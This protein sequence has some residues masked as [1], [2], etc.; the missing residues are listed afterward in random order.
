MNSIHSKCN[1]KEGWTITWHQTC[2]EYD[3][4]TCFACKDPVIR[5]E[6]FILKTP[7]D[8]QFCFHKSCFYLPGDIDH[9]LH[10]HPLTVHRSGRFVCDGCHHVSSGF[11]YQCNNIN[12][13]FKLDFSCASTLNGKKSEQI[14]ELRTSYHRHKL[15]L[16]YFR[17]SSPAKFFKDL[18]CSGCLKTSTDPLYVCSDRCGFF[19]HKSC[20]DTLPREF[21]SLF[22]PHHPLFLTTDI[23]NTT[24]E[25]C[26]GEIPGLA[27]RHYSGQMFHISCAT[28]QLT[29]GLSLTHHEHVMYY[30]I[31][32]HDDW[33]ANTSGRTKCIICNEKCNG[34]VYKCVKCYVN[35]HLE[36]IPLP[37]VVNHESH[38]H[39]LKL[40]N[41]I[42]TH[43][44]T[45]EYH[46]EICEK[47]GD[48]NHHSYYCKECDHISHI[49]CVYPE[50]M[51]II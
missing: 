49:E 40:T 41:S 34:A 5:V 36:C 51:N 24:C 4:L 20:L 17:R 48:I 31:L 39:P 6:H 50:V 37:K 35:I 43:R 15:K 38:F 19:I 28:R 21:N 29:Q 32:R 14:L 44:S 11:K 27:L 30:V 8:R 1:D 46:C 7:D 3:G 33:F 23:Y 10:H 13:S 22:H 26:N 9:P 47:V 25:V 12:C 16:V 42:V 18:V 2:R 45:D